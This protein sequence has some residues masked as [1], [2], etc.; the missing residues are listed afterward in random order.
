MNNMGF[1]SGRLLARILGFWTAKT[2]TGG[3]GSSG[4]SSSHRPWS[5]HNIV[6]LLIIWLIIY[7]AYYIMSHRILIGPGL[8]LSFSELKINFL[9]SNW[10]SFSRVSPAASPRA[11][12]L[13]RYNQCAI[14]PISAFPSNQKNLYIRWIV[15]II[16]DSAS[17]LGT[18]I[19]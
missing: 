18:D 11:K 19:S 3:L 17:D 5:R 1:L 2:D 15:P 14:P 16:V 6:P 13:M 4:R 10:E 12:Y 9:K 8:N 7:E